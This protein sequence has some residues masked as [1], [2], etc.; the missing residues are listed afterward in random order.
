[1]YKAKMIFGGR[2]MFCT[3]CGYKLED[4][5]KFCPNCGI[6]LMESEDKIL[7]QDY[8]GAN[9]QREITQEEIERLTEEIF[10]RSPL[11][12]MDNAE[13]LSKATGIPK[14]KAIKIMSAKEKIYKKERKEGKHQDRCSFC[15]SKE[16]EIYERPG[17]MSVGKVDF[18]GEGYISSTSSSTKRVRCAYCGKDFGPASR[19]IRRK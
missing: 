10:W 15:G 4:D 14:R 7:P 8:M 6:K 13:D 19:M 1:M 16:K 3:E 11:E 2:K 9:G 12:L 5:F 18:L 17:S